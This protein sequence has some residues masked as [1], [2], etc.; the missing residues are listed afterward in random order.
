MEEDIKEAAEKVPVD[1]V[2]S[3]IEIDLKI[4]QEKQTDVITA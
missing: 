3:L 2:K 1:V 4:L